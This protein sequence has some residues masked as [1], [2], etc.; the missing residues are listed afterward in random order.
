MFALWPMGRNGDFIE[1]SPNIGN[2]CNHFIF[3]S[4][5]NP[6]ESSQVIIALWLMGRNG[7]IL[8]QDHKILL[9]NRQILGKKICNHFI[10]TSILNPCESSYDKCHRLSFLMSQ[11]RFACSIGH[12]GE[13][14]Q[15]YFTKI[16]ETVTRK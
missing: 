11:T 15:I 16:C 14:P 4:I 9:K 5:L 3:T 2:M 10:F 12:F 1:K 13:K 6:W 8:G 7:D